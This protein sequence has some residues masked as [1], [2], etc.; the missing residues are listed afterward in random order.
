M[1]VDGGETSRGILDFILQRVVALLDGE[2][3]LGWPGLIG[4]R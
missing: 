4:F 1:S 2:H 3:V